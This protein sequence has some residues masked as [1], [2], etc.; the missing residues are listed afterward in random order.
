MTVAETLVALLTAVHPFVPGDHPG[1]LDGW[2]R[3]YD[4]RNS[5]QDEEICCDLAADHPVHD[6]IGAGAL[7]ELGQAYATT[8]PLGL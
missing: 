2:N 6:L 1:G 4:D 7:V 5:T 3:C 8:V